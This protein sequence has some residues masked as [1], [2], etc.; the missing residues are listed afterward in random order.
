MG[1]SVLT[2]SDSAILHRLQVT[3]SRAAGNRV[4]IRPMIWQLVAARGVPLIL[5]RCDNVSNSQNH[6]H[7]NITLQQNVIDHSISVVLSSIVSLS[8]MQCHRFHVRDRHVYIAR[9]NLRYND[10]SVYT[11]THAMHLS[12]INLLLWREASMSQWTSYS[13]AQYNHTHNDQIHKTSNAHSHLI[14]SET[15]NLPIWSIR[16]E[17]VKANFV[18]FSPTKHLFW[19]QSLP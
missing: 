15:Q 11:P 19:S 13:R 16:S 2:I 8:H 7:R 1:R 17:S 10:S 12:C 9:A 14:H 4:C 18:T 5:K 3:H 6:G